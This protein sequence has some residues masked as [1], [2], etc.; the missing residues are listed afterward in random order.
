MRVG[1]YSEEWD[2][3][4]NELMETKKFQFIDRFTAKLGNFEIWVSNHPYGSF[5]PYFKGNCDMLPKRSTAL[6]AHKKMVKDVCEQL[7]S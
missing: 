1:R 5:A 7:D 4:L 3:K 6:L 2:K